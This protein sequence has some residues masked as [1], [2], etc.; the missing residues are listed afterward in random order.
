MQLIFF[1]YFNIGI[2]LYR[3]WFRSK[4]IR[5]GNLES[6]KDHTNRNGGPASILHAVHTLI[7]VLEKTKHI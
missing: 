5:S 4:S 7:G 1:N 6:A 2:I 3:F